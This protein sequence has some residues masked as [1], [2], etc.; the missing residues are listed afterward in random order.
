VD[1][2]RSYHFHA[3]L[4]TD[5]I[6]TE[7]GPRFSISDPNHSGAVNVLTDN[8]TG[9]HSW[10]AS[11]ADFAAGPQTHFV[12][13]RL[14]RYPSRLFDNKL[15]GTVWIANLSLVPAVAQADIGKP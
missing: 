11:E 13:V 10:T 15:S 6:S 12:V 9:T 1:A 4:R 8:L 3:L 7:S 2:G 5:Q 14:V